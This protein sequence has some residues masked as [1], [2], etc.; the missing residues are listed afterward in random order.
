MP[1]I[2]PAS[3]W[4]LVRFVSADL[5]WELPEKDLN[6]LEIE[7]T[8]TEKFFDV[9]LRSFPISLEM[10]AEMVIKQKEKLAVFGKETRSPLFV[11][12]TLLNSVP[13][14]ILP[15]SPQLEAE[16]HPSSQQRDL[17]SKR[18]SG[19]LRQRWFCPGCT[20]VLPTKDPK[21]WPQQHKVEGDVSQW[22]V[23]AQVLEQNP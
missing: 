13:I 2:E 15:I 14:S 17:L 11:L 1:G 5:Q 12:G 21:Q 16:A 9:I 18:G 23:A 19:M 6:G 22:Q 3:S 4:M 10:E 20:Q 8:L 7:F